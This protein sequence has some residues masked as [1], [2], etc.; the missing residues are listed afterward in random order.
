MNYRNQSCLCGDC[1]ALVF[2]VLKAMECVTVENVTAKVAGQA[3]IVTAVPAL[4]RACQRMVPSAAGGESVSV[5]IVS[6]LYPGHLGTSV[7]SAQH[8]E[9]PVAWQGENTVMLSEVNKGVM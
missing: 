4:R 5:A 3:S 6:A 8:V 2:F 9:T 1:V 7:R